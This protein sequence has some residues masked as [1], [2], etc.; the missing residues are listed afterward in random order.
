MMTY[1]LFVFGSS[2]DLKSHSELDCADDSVAIR[3]AELNFRQA[4]MELWQ[5]DRLVRAFG[6]RPAA[7]KLA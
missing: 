1:R 6:T 4:Y 5:R 3:V 7:M 2:G